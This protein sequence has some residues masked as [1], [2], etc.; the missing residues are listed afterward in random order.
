MRTSHRATPLCSLLAGVW[1]LWLA[2][3]A[4]AQNP[5]APA[6][7]PPAAQPP[8][9]YRLGIWVEPAYQWIG[10]VWTSIGVRVTAVSPGS[11]AST[12][13]INPGDNLTA[14]NDIPVTSF[15]NLQA[16]LARS[17]G[18]ATVTVRDGRTGVVRQTSSITLA[19]APPSTTTV[20]PGSAYPQPYRYSVAR[21]FYYGNYGNAPSPNPLSAPPN[22]GSTGTYQYYPPAPGQPVTQPRPFYYGN[23]GDAPSPNPFSAPPMLGR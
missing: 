1:I 12:A 4:A 14:V 6:S 18:R 17:D 22:Y 9:N 21:P 19:V 3:L 16:A 23:Y 13:S 8:P 5:P 11:P 10:Q 20:P 2:T 15:A 7:A